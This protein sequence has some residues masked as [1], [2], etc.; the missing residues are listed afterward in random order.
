MDIDG[1]R[2]ISETFEVAGRFF[3]GLAHVRLRS[4]RFAYI[5]KRG[6]YIFEY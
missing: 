3:H 4:G 6:K 1:K 2:V 5:D